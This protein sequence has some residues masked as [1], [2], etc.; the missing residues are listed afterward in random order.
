MTR[1]RFT[2]ATVFALVCLLPAAFAQDAPKTVN[3]GVVNGK[4]ISLP[5]PVYPEAARAAGTGGSISVNVVIDESGTVIS[6]EA[7]LYDQR[8]Q[9][10]SDGKKLDPVEADI[11]L[12]E[13]AEAAARLAK[14]SPTWLR[15]EPVRVKGMIVYNFVADKGT[16]TEFSR[17]G[18]GVLKTVDETHRVVSGGVLNGKAI[19]LPKP[20]YPAAAKAVRA[21]G[22][23]AVEVTIDESGSVTNAAAVSGHP[24]LRAAAEKAAR[25]AKFE[26]TLLDGKPVMVSGI[27]TYNFVLPKKDDQ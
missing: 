3:G 26:P 25:G 14:F 23:V 12:R 20:A 27:L 7:D 10:D 15:N 17:P 6:A 21:E 16:D 2:V 4:A 13:A 8:G 18:M 5:K 1:I 11:S 24:L 19:E 9:F 22:A